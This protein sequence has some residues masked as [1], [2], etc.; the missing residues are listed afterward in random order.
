MKQILILPAIG[1]LLTGCTTTAPVTYKFPDVPPELMVPAEPLKDLP[2]GKKPELSD[3]LKNVN[4]N[5]GHYYELRN[6]YNLWI[7]WYN[8]Q[9]KIHEDATK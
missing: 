4:E 1:L 3:I 9:K 2:K 5:Y 6:K 7:D 8:Q